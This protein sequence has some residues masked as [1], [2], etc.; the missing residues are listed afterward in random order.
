[1]KIEI[2]VPSSEINIEEYILKKTK[3]I[4]EKGIEARL[5]V[6]PAGGGGEGSEVGGS[7]G[8]LTKGGSNETL[9]YKY[10]KRMLDRIF[11]PNVKLQPE[12]EAS[13]GILEETEKPGVLGYFDKLFK[14][15]VAPAAEPAAEP[16]V[17][18]AAEPEE[19]PAAEPEEE[20]EEEPA[21]EPEEEPAAEPAAE[22]SVIKEQPSVIEEQPSVIKEQPSVI[23][24]QPSITE[25]QPSI[26]EE[27]P[28]I[29]EEQP[30]VIEEQPSV[31]EEQPPITEEQPPITEEQP[32]AEPAEEPAAEP[33]P[34]KRKIIVISE[35]EIIPIE[36]IIKK[37]NEREERLDETIERYK[38]EEIPKK[39]EMGKMYKIGG[40]I[41]NLGFEKI[42]IKIENSQYE[43]TKKWYMN[44][45]T[46][47]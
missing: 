9:P 4:I 41:I 42:E 2:E 38:Y 14:P 27:Q 6:D 25:E 11:K 39:E 16:A 45:N 3:E 33:E 47:V 23:E 7:Y 44:N 24:E 8:L 32:A 37:R 26:T 1:M 35:K 34:Q 10:L 43:G 19:E 46:M 28:S 36:E 31:I 29:T 22:P 13:S 17:E 5:E 40:K 12:L 18:P 21:A 20:P 30:S 15:A